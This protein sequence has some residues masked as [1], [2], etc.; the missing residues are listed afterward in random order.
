MTFTVSST[1]AS[2]TSSSIPAGYYTLAISLN[3]GSTNVA[4]KTD[5]VRI[6]SG[7]TTS[8]TYTWSTV[9]QIAQVGGVNVTITPSLASPFV[10]SISGGQSTIYTGANL[11]LTASVSGSPSGVSYAWYVNGVSQNTT[12]ATWSG[13]SSWAAGY[14]T[15][16][17]TAISSDN[18]QAGSTSFA[19]K[20][21]MFTTYSTNGQSND[22]VAGIAVSGSTIYAATGG[23]GLAVSNDQGKSW[24]TYT[25][26]NGLGYGVTSVFVSGSSIYTE[27]EG[28]LSY[29][30]NGGSSW[31]NDPT[32]SNLSS[33]TASGSTIYGVCSAGL[34]VFTYGGHSCSTYSMP[35]IGSNAIYK[36]VVTGSSIY[37]ATAGGLSVSTDNGNTWKTYKKSDGLCSSMVYGVAVSGST[38][39]AATDSGVSVSTDGGS[40]WT[41]YTSLNGLDGNYISNIAVSGTTVYAVT[42]GGYS[43]S[44]STNNGLNWT[45]FTTAN[46]LGSDIFGLAFSGSIIYAA[47]SNGVSISN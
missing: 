17:V 35:T 20:V 31:T 36:V 47:T 44:V 45:V 39:Y 27:G 9:N 34:E 5:I 30:S 19:V 21:L 28:G 10:V 15:I 13:G 1:S 38:I 41:N 26:A 24:T 33:F 23:Y 11:N 22:W 8:G 3:D 37:L 43:L 14:Y 2:Y 29:S 16:D 46:G 32:I 40:N 4:G 7:Q 6:V 42:G 12:T 25:S 18:T